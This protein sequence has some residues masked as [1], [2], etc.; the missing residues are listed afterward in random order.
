MYQRFLAAAKNAVVAPIRR[1]VNAVNNRALGLVGRQ[2]RQPAPQAPAQPRNEPEEPR[3]LQGRF[4]IITQIIQRKRR[5]R[6]GQQHADDP[7]DIT[8]RPQIYNLTVAS[9]VFN[10]LPDGERIF[11]HELPGISDEDFAGKTNIPNLLAFLDGMMQDPGDAV[12]VANRLRNLLSSPTNIIIDEIVDTTDDLAME[13]PEWIGG[14]PLGRSRYVASKCVKYRSNPDAISFE[15]FIPLPSE[16][17]DDWGDILPSACMYNAILERFKKGFDKYF[18]SRNFS[19]KNPLFRQ[20]LTFDFLAN[21]FG[22][23]LSI[24]ALLSMNEAKTFFEKYKLNLFIQDRF[25]ELLFSV[26]HPNPTT[27]ILPNT[28]WLVYH[29]Q[30]VEIIRGKNEIRQHGLKSKRCSE[31]STKPEPFPIYEPVEAPVCLVNNMDE[32]F[33]VFKNAK[34]DTT[35]IYNQKGTTLVKQLKAFYDLGYKP[36]ITAT[37]GLQFDSMKFFNINDVNITVKTSGSV[38]GKR[39]DFENLDHY[40]AYKKAED[41]LY[42][43]FTNKDLQS[44]FSEDTLLALRKHDHV[45][46][47]YRIVE[48]FTHEDF[49]TCVGIDGSWFY[50]S[51]AMMAESFY[52]ITGDRIDYNGEDLIDENLYYYEILEKHPLFPVNVSHSWGSNLKLLTKYGLKYTI[53]GMNIGIKHSAKDIQKTITEIMNSD[54]LTR[55][56]KKFLLVRAIGKSGKNKMVQN[57]FTIYDDLKSSS[58]D[59]K[60]Y[61]SMRYEIR[62]MFINRRM[63]KDCVLNTGFLMRDQILDSARTTLFGFSYSLRAKGIV[64][65]AYKTDCIVLRKKDLDE[66]LDILDKAGIAIGTGMG[67]FKVQEDVCMPTNLIEYKQVNYAQHTGI[68]VKV[69][70]EDLSV[71]GDRTLII[72]A[73]GVGKTSVLIKRGIE[74]FGCEQ[75]LVV[76]PMKKQCYDINLKWKVQTCTVHGFMGWDFNK[77]TRA[78]ECRSLI[79]IKCVILDE[80]M[81]SHISDIFHISRRID[82]LEVPLRLNNGMLLH[83]K[84]LRPEIQGTCDDTQLKGFGENIKN[85]QKMSVLQMIFKTIVYVSENKRVKP[86]DRQVLRQLY[87]SVKKGVTKKQFLEIAGGKVLTSLDDLKK[88][89]IKRGLCLSNIERFT[90]NK[91]IHKNVPRVTSNR[92]RSIKKFTILSNE[93]DYWAGLELVCNSRFKGKLYPNMRVKISKIKDGLFTLIYEDITVEATSDEIT[94]FFELP[95]VGTVYS[96]QGGDIQENFIIG[97]Y[98]NEACDLEWLHTAYSRCIDRDHVFWFNFNL[99]WENIR[100]ECKRMIRGYQAQDKLAGREISDFVTEQSIIDK[101]KVSRKCPNCGDGM[102]FNKCDR[103]KVTCQRLNNDI[104]HSEK[105]CILMCLECNKAL[106]NH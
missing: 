64:E 85:I 32:L 17:H 58:M 94:C 76:C 57:E 62:G 56:D 2:M 15:D 27:H 70:Y 72:G 63:I 75:V 31:V 106:S 78:H 33:T 19:A 35:V 9:R 40:L 79:G 55:D 66:A 11:T 5:D 93:I 49:Q 98:L 34:C 10:T 12:S 103:H 101:F 48:T 39:N 26:E 3:M 84:G 102:S 36:R 83:I 29:D 25:G 60:K 8:T 86:K 96:C 67:Q 28:L 82:E 22:K 16:I 89:N 81:M 20:K 18:A 71:L 1:G 95:Y 23:D 74:K 87:E 77:K 53:I 46:P 61:G 90:L 44:V 50:P 41:K 24:N 52:S 4:K 91:E 42:S 104:C 88:Y 51:Q 105:N 13:Y 14:I 68:P 21:F 100:N 97:E 30:H 54:E 6:R 59:N 99:K 47:S 73:P 69:F 65:L 92:S 7:I 45:I 43:A 38:I 37:S 80:S